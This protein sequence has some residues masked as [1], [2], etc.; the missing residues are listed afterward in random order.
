MKRLKKIAND[1]IYLKDIIDPI[2]IHLLSGDT[3]EY[4]VDQQNRDFAIVLYDG[5]IYEGPTHESAISNIDIDESKPCCFANHITGK[6]GK[7]YVI[8]YQY[9][10][11]ISKEEAIPFFKE[12]YP[13]AIICIEDELL[14]D[15][16]AYVIKVAEFLDS[17]SKNGQYV[18]VFKN[19]TSRELGEVLRNDPNNS[20]RGCIDGSDLY[21]WSSE[22]LHY[23]INQFVSISAGGIRFVIEDG[24]NISFSNYTSDNQLFN[25]LSKTKSQFESCMGSSADRILI[26]SDVDYNFNYASMQDY[27]DSNSEMSNKVSRLLKNRK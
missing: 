17:F 6:D 18:E 14:D 12:R 8:L 3:E 20:A 1:I 16:N 21:I 15:D 24:Y 25:A 19:P 4:L 2:T 26:S 9:M 13:N 10:D 5:N 22:I 23:I 27:L 11:N 7:E